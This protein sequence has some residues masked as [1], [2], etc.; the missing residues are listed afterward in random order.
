MKE[1]YPQ[2]GLGRI[3]G[4]FG[5]SRQGYYSWM[6]AVSASKIQDEFIIQL[7][8]ELRK[9]H[10]K[11]GVRK[12]HHML[13]N[14][15]NRLGIR[16]GRDG[17]FDLLSAYNLLIVKRKRSIRTTQSNHRFRKYPNLV[18][19]FDPR[20]ANQVW[21]SDIT[22]I[23]HKDS[24]KYLFLIT[25][26]YSKKI[27]GYSLAESLDSR[28]AV[29]A[30]QDAISK[31]GQPISGLIHHS[32]RG[33]QYCSNDYVKVLQNHNIQIS[34]TEN[35]D[36]R[37]NAVAERVNGVLK[38]EYL[39]QYNELTTLQLDVSV[40]KYNELRPH[41]SCDMHTPS[42]AHS[43]NGVLKKRWKNYYRTKENQL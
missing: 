5:I 17:L 20:K 29:N 18:R 36:P 32:D 12:L 10:P 41:L 31:C 15:F 2:V 30:L 39:S 8:V 14:D 4:L 3:S 9:D 43:L 13:K 16:M 37:E 26:V 25:D 1:C 21:A 22:Y 7:V 42:Y 6:N 33:I 23:R 19:E 24:F 11:M 40:E 28:H 27:V 38:N 34:M 35:G